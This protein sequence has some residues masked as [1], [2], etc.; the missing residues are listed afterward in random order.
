MHAD[1]R[2][3][4]VDGRKHGLSMENTQSEAGP[5][6]VTDLDVM[7]TLELLS[8]G[9]ADRCEHQLLVGSSLCRFLQELSQKVRKPFDANLST[10][11]HR[12]AGGSSGASSPLLCLS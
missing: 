6:K 12:A 5:E 4:I 2:Q 11:S 3:V 8:S 10:Y 7:F 9:G 1:N